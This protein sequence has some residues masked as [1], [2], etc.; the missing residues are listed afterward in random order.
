MEEGDRYISTDGR[1]LCMVPYHYVYEAT[2]KG[3]WIGL[4]LLTAFASEFAVVQ[5]DSTA[6][7]VETAAEKNN[8]DAEDKSSAEL[9]VSLN[10]VE[11]MIR[12]ASE[13]REG[14]LFAKG[15][16]AECKR[17]GETYCAWFDECKQSRPTHWAALTV[18]GDQTVRVLLD[19]LPQLVVLGQRDTVL[20][21]MVRHEGHI[22]AA[23]PLEIYHMDLPCA[24]ASSP[25][26]PPKPLP[27]SPQAAEAEQCGAPPPRGEL[28]GYHKTKHHNK[29][30]RNDAEQQPRL[31]AP[32]SIS[33]MFVRKPFGMP[34]HPSGKYRKN[35]VTMM[36]ED[37]FGGCDAHRYEAVPTEE[38]GFV[39]Q[40]RVHKFP[41]VIVRSSVAQEARDWLASTLSSVARP[42][43]LP[44]PTPRLKLFVVHRLDVG[45]TGILMFGLDSVSA[46]F[47]TGLLARKTASLNRMVLGSCNKGSDS[48]DD[49]DNRPREG[50]Y[51]PESLLSGIA[52]SYVARVRGNLARL[53]DDTADGKVLRD[54]VGAER[55]AFRGSAVL[56]FNRPIFCR[57]FFNSFY[58]CPT[59]AEMAEVTRE[60]RTQW[61]R[62]VRAGNNGGS[63]DVDARAEQKG[64]GEGTKQ[65]R[66]RSAVSKR[67]IERA[68]DDA[69]Q[70]VAERFPQ[71]RTAVSVFSPLRFDPNTNE[72][73]VECFP[74]TGRTHQLRVHL[75]ALGFPI[76]N[77]TKY[78]MREVVPV[79]AWSAQGTSM[80]QEA[81]EIYLHAHRYSVVLQEEQD[82]NPEVNRTVTAD[83]PRWAEEAAASTKSLQK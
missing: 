20:H 65:D 28:Y 40:H 6:L 27:P 55:A 24:A 29:R 35:S 41:L 58:D 71:L 44:Q 30:A 10:K 77:D 75:A 4:P 47:V 31:A 78:C 8:G 19:E 57:S 37:T 61:E 18:D 1:S 83:L 12:Y 14:T 34:V 22:P 21:A 76:A 69:A 2:V 66:L 16:E 73:I 70:S 26:T 7:A 25:P 62:F 36:L 74:V 81:Q 13:M 63:L 67:P 38:G 51:S 80:P 32:T 64:G 56:V 54:R 42:D 60:L 52:K 15:R 46:R 3:R 53:L 45:T 23:S 9:H 79:N 11:N 50:Y 49:V 43:L 82:G 39:V 33:L 72:S 59:D 5:T 48:A 17:A 68:G